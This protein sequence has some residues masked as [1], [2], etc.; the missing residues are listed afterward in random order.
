VP[1]H[2]TKCRS[3]SS[4]FLIHRGL[5]ISR[6]RGELKSVVGL[7]VLIFRLGGTDGKEAFF[8]VQSISSIVIEY[9]L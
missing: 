2:F 4:K 3:I 6:S 7:F 8:Y 5:K 9:W 1:K